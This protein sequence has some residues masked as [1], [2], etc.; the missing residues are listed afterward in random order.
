MKKVFAV[1][2]PPVALKALESP[3][4]GLGPHDLLLL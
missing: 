2:P 3:S 1:D 4:I